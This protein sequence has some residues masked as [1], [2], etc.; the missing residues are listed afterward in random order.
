MRNNGPSNAGLTKF[1]IQWPMT[2][3]NGNYLLYLMK[4]EPSQGISC[5]VIGKVNPLELIVSKPL[6]LALLNTP[7]PPS[8]SAAPPPP[9][10]WSVLP[11]YYNAQNSYWSDVLILAQ[12]S[13]WFYQL[14]NDVCKN[15]ILFRVLWKKNNR[16][17]TRVGFKPRTSR[18]LTLTLTLTKH[19]WTCV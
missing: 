13:F 18:V 11:W 1:D 14:Y 6:L 19:T 8:I 17:I 10:E 7:P 9:P 15:C 3:E 2:D 16:Q 12:S 4:V 5:D